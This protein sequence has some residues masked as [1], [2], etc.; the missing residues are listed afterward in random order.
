MYEDYSPLDYEDYDLEISDN[1]ED[2]LYDQ[3][4]EQ[5]AIAEYEEQQRQLEMEEREEDV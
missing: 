1:N 3:M 4:K 2:F 5:Q